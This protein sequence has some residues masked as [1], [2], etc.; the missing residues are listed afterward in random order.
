MTSGIQWLNSIAKW[1]PTGCKDAWTTRHCSYQ[2]LY[3][4]PVCRDAKIVPL[5]NCGTSVFA[6]FTIFSIIGFM[7]HETGSSV[8]NVIK[9][10]KKWL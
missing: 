7:A 10:G 1:K 3:V 5:L 4:F 2:W 6:G 8:D 9:Q